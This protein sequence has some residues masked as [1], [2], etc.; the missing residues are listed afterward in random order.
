MLRLF[1]HKEFIAQHLQ[2]IGVFYKVVLFVL[3]E[4]DNSFVV[5]NSLV[6]C[7]DYLA[8]C[9]FSQYL[10]QF[11]YFFYAFDEVHFLHA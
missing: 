2:H 1:K 10:L 8:K 4:R 9:P 7:F 6:N 5:G 11:V 3:L